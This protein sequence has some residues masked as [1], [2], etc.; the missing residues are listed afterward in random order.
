[1]P[2]GKKAG[3]CQDEHLDKCM[4]FSG[5]ALDAPPQIYKGSSSPRPGCS[6]LWGHQHVYIFCSVASSRR[7]YGF[8]ISGQLSY[9]K[10]SWLVQRFKGQ[11]LEVT[12]PILWSLCSKQPGIIGGYTVLKHVVCWMLFPCVC[13]LTVSLMVLIQWYVSRTVSSSIMTKKIPTNIRWHDSKWHLIFLSKLLIRVRNSFEKYTFL[14]YCKAQYHSDIWTV[15]IRCEG[16]W[17]AKV[18][19]W[20]FILPI[21][22]LTP[23]KLD[24]PHFGQLSK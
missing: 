21:R 14:S 2:D 12:N 1:M 13:F 23:R 3:R 7:Q 4:V 9:C 6:S 19:F 22:W 8:R 17:M 20:V 11:V 15:N 16:R 18:S 5:T 24:L 10:L